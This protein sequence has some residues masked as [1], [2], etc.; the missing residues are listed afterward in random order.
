MALGVCAVRFAPSQSSFSNFRV[1]VTGCEGSRYRACRRKCAA[2]SP[3][4]TCLETYSDLLRAGRPDALRRR[5]A[6]LDRI[7][8]GHSVTTNTSCGPRASGA[9]GEVDDD[10]AA[11][12]EEPLSRAGWTT[13]PSRGSRYHVFDDALAA[14]TASDIAALS[15]TPTMRACRIGTAALH[16]RTHTQA[17]AQKPPVASELA[18]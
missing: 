16:T 15:A 18:R 3:L 4:L 14:A 12:V 5:R 1:G 17:P 7:P 8:T 10:A 9:N 11:A 6:G 13:T 2:I